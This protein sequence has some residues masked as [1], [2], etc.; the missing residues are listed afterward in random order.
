MLGTGQ[1]ISR[2]QSRP[3]WETRGL[4]PCER[5]AAMWLSIPELLPA[6][7]SISPAHSQLASLLQQGCIVA[8]WL[9]AHRAVQSP[10]RYSQPWWEHSPSLAPINPLL[11]AWL[12]ALAH[13][14]MPLEAR[15]SLSFTSVLP[16]LCT[17]VAEMPFGAQKQCPRGVCSPRA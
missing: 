5:K 15:H 17:A 12:G 10:A 9:P 16:A 1:A 4:S 6:G 11:G 7:D 3:L 13:S 14:P 8:H 2:G